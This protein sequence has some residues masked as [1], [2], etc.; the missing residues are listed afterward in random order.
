MAKRQRS[1]SLS[2]VLLRFAIVMLGCTLLCGMIW[3]SGLSRLQN[4]SIVYRGIVPSQQVEKMLAGEPETFRS[5]GED[6]LAEYAL[7]GKNGEVLECNVK[8]EKLEVLKSLLQEKSHEADTLRYTYAD[9]STVIF[10]WYYRA[11]FADPMLRDWLPPF[12]YLWIA[13]FGTAVAFCVLVNTLW[14][15]RRLAARLKLFSE[16]SEKIGT[17]ELDFVIPHAGIREYDQALDAMEHMREALYSSLSSQWAAQQEREA[18]IAALAHDLKTPLTLVGGNAELLLGEELSEN[19]RKM[20]EKI[21]SGNE[22]AK[23]YVASLLET[24]AGAE[25]AF[26]Y[27]SLPAVF[28]ELCLNTTA[29]AETKGVCLQARNGLEGGADIQKEHLL[30]ALGNVVQN[31]IEHTPAGKNVYFE[32]SMTENGWQIVVRDEG[33]GFSKAALHHATERLWRGDA[34]RG[35]DGHNGLGLWFAA[36]VAK[37]HAAQL[38]LRNCKSGGM[39]IFSFESLSCQG[40]EL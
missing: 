28:E 29:I 32:G 11:E 37:T 27:T 33:A 7:F 5:P 6:F 12:E 8:G 16:V 26:E 14:L 17:Q 36:E 19:S 13:A 23:Q 25:E 1:V 34:A 2:F 3:F 21:L 10:H 22:R 30:R 4:T 35:A 24:S 18:E 20:V 39:V 9:G 31:A 40:Q 38:E 15:R